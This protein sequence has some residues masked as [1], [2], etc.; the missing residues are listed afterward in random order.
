MKLVTAIVQPTRLDDLKITLAHLGV[1]GMTISRAEGYGRQKGRTEVY[2]GAQ[3]PVEFL[4]KL[5]LEV[6]AEDTEVG[7][8]VDGIVATGRTGNL[9]DGKVWVTPVETVVRVRTGET[10]TTAL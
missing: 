9:G 10:D 7:R 4:D 6:L 1:Q 5:R 3:Y 8:I 2:R